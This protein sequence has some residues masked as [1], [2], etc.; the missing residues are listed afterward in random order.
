MKLGRL[1]TNLGKV[2]KL[3]FLDISTNNLAYLPESMGKLSKLEYINFDHNELVLSGGCFS[4]MLFLKDLKMRSNL[5]RHLFAD[6]GNC[7]NLQRLDLQSNK[8]VLIPPGIILIF[9][10]TRE[11]SQFLIY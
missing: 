9:S 6:L 5:V 11:D 10:M 7:I 2:D 3:T 1:P 8:L 4:E